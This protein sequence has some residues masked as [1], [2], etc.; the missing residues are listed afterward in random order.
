MVNAV[1]FHTEVYCALLWSFV[2]AG[3]DAEAF[4]DLQATAGIEDVI[5]P[6][7]SSSQL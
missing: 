3:V 4:V 6:W 7:C 1:N 2:R 5:R